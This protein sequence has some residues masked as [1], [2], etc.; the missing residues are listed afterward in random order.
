MSTPSERQIHAAAQLW[1]EPQ[2]GHKVMD[3]DFA[4]SIAN[5]LA[6][7]RDAAIEECAKV[8]DAEAWRLAKMLLSADIAHQIRA[9]NALSAYDTAVKGGG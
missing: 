5:A 9:L 7:E 2:H 3:S 8:A 4:M 6:A 1:C